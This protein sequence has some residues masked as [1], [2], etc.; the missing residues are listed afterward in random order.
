[1][2]DPTPLRLQ[3]SF[4]AEYRNVVNIGNPMNYHEWLEAE[5]TAARLAQ[6][7][8]ERRAEAIQVSE[9]ELFSKLKAAE[10]RLTEALQCRDAWHDA[11]LY[12][13]ENWTPD[14][15][16]PCPAC[17][18]AN[19]KLLRL[20]RLHEAL[21]AASPPAREQPRWLG[22]LDGPRQDE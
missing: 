22:L 17:L 9:A 3:Q 16:R 19:G 15:P 18:Y 2:A 1:M 5:L 10:S 7:E 8:A 13:R 6:Q 20:C 11:L 21:A 4:V 12:L 14:D